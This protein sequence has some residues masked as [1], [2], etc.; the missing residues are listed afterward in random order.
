MR[1]GE[2][3]SAIASTRKRACS[4]G[5]ECLDAGSLIGISESLVVGTAHTLNALR[6][7]VR[8]SNELEVPT[9]VRTLR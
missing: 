4:S 3:K 9:S 5:I 7:T 2:P 8:A 1:S 6:I